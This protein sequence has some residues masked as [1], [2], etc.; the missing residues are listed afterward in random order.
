MQREEKRYIDYKPLYPPPAKII[1]QLLLFYQ[2]AK[3]VLV[4]DS[5]MNFE[6]YFPIDLKPEGLTS[7]VLHQD[8]DFID[9]VGCHS[10]RGLGIADYVLMTAQRPL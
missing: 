10:D 6:Q 7:A 5:Q 8:Q 1:F 3:N 2:T 4:S 9:L